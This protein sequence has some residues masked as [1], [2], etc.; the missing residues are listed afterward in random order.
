[1]PARP[2]YRL[3]KLLALLAAL[4]S[5]VATDVPL[6]SNDPP[7]L[8]PQALP[9]VEEGGVFWRELVRASKKRSPSASVCR[10]ALQSSEGWWLELRDDAQVLFHAHEAPNEEMVR[11]WTVDRR[12]FF[13]RWL[14]TPQPVL[15]LQ[16][17]ELRLSAYTSQVLR[18]WSRCADDPE[19]E[20]LWQRRSGHS[21]SGPSG[22]GLRHTSSAPPDGQ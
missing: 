9:E 6:N 2:Q 8:S 21:A 14:G 18:A 12:Q 7:S 3:L 17:G 15:I 11:T 16:D 22:P 5:C 4:S 19:S 1:M 20:A 13:E 10:H